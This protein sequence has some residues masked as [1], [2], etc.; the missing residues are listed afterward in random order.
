[1]VTMVPS[2]LQ[3][4]RGGRWPQKIWFHRCGK[5][6]CWLRSTVFGWKNDETRVKHAVSQW[7]FK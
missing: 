1:M 3:P 2:L 6:F 4:L 5:D 7:H